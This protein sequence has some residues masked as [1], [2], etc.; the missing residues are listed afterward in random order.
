MHATFAVW[1]P[2]AV[3]S[4]L[5]SKLVIIAIWLYSAVITMINYK[6]YTKDPDGHMPVSINLPLQILYLKISLHSSCAGTR[7]RLLCW[8]YSGSNTGIG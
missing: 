6:A 3:R 7:R 5:M 4:I 8:S 2:G 1:W